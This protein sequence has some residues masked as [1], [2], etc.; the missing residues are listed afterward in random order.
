MPTRANNSLHAIAS[1]DRSQSPDQTVRCRGSHGTTQN[2][3]SPAPVESIFTLSE[4]FPIAY[5]E[6][7][8]PFTVQEILT[9]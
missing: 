4:S 5:I 9:L 8:V 7:Y 2:Q 1:L 3:T 6:H